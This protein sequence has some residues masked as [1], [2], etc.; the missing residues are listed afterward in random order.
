MT[1]ANIQQLGPNAWLVFGGIKWKPLIGSGLASKSQKEAVAVKATHF[2]AAGAHSAAVGTIQLP[3]EKKEKV[4]RKLYSAAAIFAASHPTGAVIA[5][6]KTQGDKFWVVGSHDGMVSKG[7]DVI[8]TAAEAD[9]IVNDFRRRHSNA[10]LVAG[11][12][13]DLNHYLNSS[14][15]LQTVKTLIEK[16][17]TPVKV[18]VGVLL[19]LMLIDTGWGHWKKYKLRQLREQNIEQ[20]VDSHAE[21][22][23]TLNEWAKSIKTD[24]R[25]GLTEL[26]A[27]MGRIPL[28]VGHWKLS[29]STCHQV[30]S[31]WSCTARYFRTVNATNLSFTENIPEGW[32]ASWDGLTTAIGSWKLKASRMPL[33]RMSIPTV[34]DFSINYISQ[35]QRVLPAYRKVELQPPVKVVIATPTVIQ[36]NQGRNEA[37]QVPYP[38]DNLKGIEIPSVQKFTFNGPLRS[39]TVLPITDETVIKSLH[40]F[41]E[42]RALAPSLR[43]SISMAELIGETYVK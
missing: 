38:T 34:E 1:D 40:F 12:E 5:R 16:I 7:T 41:V 20:F 23:T 9:E 10:L 6:E 27:E 32:S 24:G 35:L 8:C 2:V 37:I 25:K 3:A 26:Y 36:V 33:A 18:G 43:D 29:E 4:A 21:W 19:C 42:S 14:T 17:P 15:E 30:G 31:G 39:L 11:S 13:T 22:T 28:D